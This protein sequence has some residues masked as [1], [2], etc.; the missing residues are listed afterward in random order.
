MYSAIKKGNVS[1]SVDRGE[2]VDRGS[3]SGEESSHL[4]CL[5]VSRVCVFVLNMAHFKPPV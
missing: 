1:E 4:Q 5:S 2:P 3:F